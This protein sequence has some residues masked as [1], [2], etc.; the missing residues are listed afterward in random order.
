MSPPSPCA[1][2]PLL[3]FSLSSSPYPLASF[4]LS[5]PSGKFPP[6]DSEATTNFYTK[7]HRGHLE[8]D[9]VTNPVWL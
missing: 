4:H 5:K 8:S 3:S 6:Q 7:T 9:C 1:R 2:G